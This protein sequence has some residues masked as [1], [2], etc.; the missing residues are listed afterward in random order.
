MSW[1]NPIIKLATSPS[2]MS[3]CCKYDKAM[4][5]KAFY[6][7]LVFDGV[8]Q[9]IGARAADIIDLD[10]HL[11]YEINHNRFEEPAAYN[12]RTQ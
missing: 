5:R 4:L 11:F 2:I 9:L 1:L 10:I 6:R 7:E 12:C 3:D 8:M